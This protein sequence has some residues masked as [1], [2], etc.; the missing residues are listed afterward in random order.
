[1]ETTL[2]NAFLLTVAVGAVLPAL[3]A[4]VTNRWASSQLKSIILLLLT[5][6]ASVLNPIVGNNDVNWRTVATTF[7]VTFG[8]AVLTYYGALKPL[9]IAG[10]DGKIQT[11][12]PG[13]IG[14]AEEVVVP[15]EDES[16]LDVSELPGYDEVPEEIS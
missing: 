6:A 5:A 16:D 8:S 7:V 11:A 14:K 3:V 10:T 1:M 12:I 13:G 9:N 2:N 4:V 15:V